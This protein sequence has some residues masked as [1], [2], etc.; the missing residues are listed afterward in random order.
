MKYSDKSF[1]KNIPVL[2]NILKNS[3]TIDNLRRN[4]FESLV[5][6]D[7]KILII[8]DE[9]DFGSINTDKI[10]KPSVLYTSIENLF[11]RFHNSK[12][13]LQVT[14]TPYG[15]I[16]SSNSISLKAKKIIS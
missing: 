6:K 8:D 5:L 1:N 3:K 12:K 2:F 16:L 13:L 4:I 11:N 15:N 7:K 9:V 10:E 14:A